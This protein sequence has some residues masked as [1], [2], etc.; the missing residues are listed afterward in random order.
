MAPTSPQRAGFGLYDRPYVLLSLTM[1]FWAANM[2]AGRLAAGHVPPIAL[3]QM[4]WSLAM[5]IL[6]PFAV[7]P[8]RRDW[9]VIRRNPMI[10]AVLG[11]FGISLYNTLVY[12]ALQS[13]TAINATMLA[14]IFPMMIAATGFLL[15]RDRL[16]LMQFI[17]ILVSCAGAGV[18]LT[19]GSVSALLGLAF[20]PGDL[21]VI[22]AQVAYAIYTVM[23]R[24][25]PKLHPISFLALTVFAGQLFLVP[26]TLF[27]ASRG[28]VVTLDALTIAI[29]VF[30]AIVPAILAFTCFNRGVELVGSNR[31]APFFHLVPVFTSVAAIAFL[32]EHLAV[33]HLVGWPLIL[34]GIAVTQLYRAPRQAL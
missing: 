8:I 19:K 6:I 17:G 12:I 20:N 33:Y 27:E 28:A 31:A 10:L 29:V 9:P 34:A 25:R 32:G 26:F 23:L 16:T 30:I 4:R 11:F 14:S 7:G 1:L 18:I 21:W 3:A 24:K 15:Y 5:I 13:T 2:I 22:G